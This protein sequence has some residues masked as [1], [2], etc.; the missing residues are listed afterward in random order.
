MKQNYKLWYNPT[1]KR[2]SPVH[3]G[4][5]ITVEFNRVV[6]FYLNFIEFDSWYATT[7]APQALTDD[8][9]YFVSAINQ[10]R[11]ND[12]RVLLADFMPKES[13]IL[14]PRWTC[15]LNT[16]GNTP[17]LIFVNWDNI[18][19]RISWKMSKETYSG[20]RC[21]NTHFY[22]DDYNALDIQPVRKNM[23]A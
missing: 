12:N 13:H 8:M 20:S 5:S 18:D 11:G 17:E 2:N 23:A 14:M 4:Y 22:V 9:K 15:M 21:I 7:Q 19:R 1:P 16:E 3:K 6:T 10:N